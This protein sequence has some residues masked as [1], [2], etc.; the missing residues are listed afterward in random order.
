MERNLN[1]RARAA[2]AT[3]IVA[4]ASLTGTGTAL[5]LDEIPDGPEVCDSRCTPV[6]VVV[7]LPENAFI[8]IDEA[9]IK[10]GS[11]VPLPNFF[12]KIESE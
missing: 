3:S 6:E 9:F 11:T 10:L 2:I 8:K 1:K 12:L 5:A 4:A 7:F